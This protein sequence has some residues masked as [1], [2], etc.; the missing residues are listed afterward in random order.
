M[1]KTVLWPILL[2][3]L[4]ACGLQSSNKDAPTTAPTLVPTLFITPTSQMTPSVTLSPT[5]LTLPPTPIPNRQPTS[6]PP[7]TSASLGPDGCT[8][9]SRFVSDI[10]IPDESPIHPA[11]PFIKTWRLRNTGTCTWGN[12]YQFVKLEGQ[13]IPATNAVIIPV[14]PPGAEV[15]IS[16]SLSIPANAATGSQQIARFQ[17]RDPQGAYFGQ[18]PF[19]TVR[20]DPNAGITATPSCT[21][22][23][24]FVADV[25]IPDGT[26]LQTGVA[27]TKT[28][29]IK[30]S[31]TCA[32]GA[33]YVL[34]KISTD[35]LIP[36]TTAVTIPATAAGATT[37]ISIEL[38]IPIGTPAGT[39]LRAQFQ[40]LDPQGRLF[41]ATP[42]TEVIAG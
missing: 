34:I 27:F 5:H 18:K 41:G 8:N 19:V 26:I 40:M 9:N 31:G 29:R 17:L 11:A 32:W 37:D 1:K 6:A 16:V 21:N 10:T 4:C 39:T 20:V 14:T 2:L 36:T 35:A 12:G 42:Y 38:T 15:D 24:D 22:D 13:L 23:S 30:N 25:T 7:P 3:I 28:W 33:G